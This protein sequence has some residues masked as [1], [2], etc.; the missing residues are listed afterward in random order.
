MTTPEPADERPEQDERSEQPERTWAGNRPLDTR[1][2]WSP[3]L[4]VVVGGA[5]IGYQVAAYRGEGGGTWLN[6][7]M[8]LIGGAVAVWGLVSLV[9][10]YRAEHAQAA[11]QTPRTDAP[12]DAAPPPV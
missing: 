9:H 11:S 8:I 2:W 7:A 6:A 1:W 12:D 10:A 3:A 4:M 5:V